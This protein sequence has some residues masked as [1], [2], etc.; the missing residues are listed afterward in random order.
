MQQQKLLTH[1][2]RDPLFIHSQVMC[3]SFFPAAKLIKVHNFPNLFHV[4]NCCL[5][6]RVAAIA[7]RRAG[8]HQ[9]LPLQMCF[10]CWKL[11]WWWMEAEWGKARVPFG[12][13]SSFPCQI[14]LTT[15]W[16][17]M[18]LPS[19]LP[20]F[21][22]SAAASWSQGRVF[23]PLENKGRYFQSFNSFF[24]E[25]FRDCYFTLSSPVVLNLQNNF[26]L[27][28]FLFLGL[29]CLGMM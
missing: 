13:N 2:S 9:M 3:F 7:T 8:L 16:S 11:V 17:Y 26:H 24:L 18:P 19:V 4:D 12:L 20:P 15:I 23:F 25:V 6:H 5:C 29:L 21:D 27:P 28:D 1:L 10:R 22:F 14:P